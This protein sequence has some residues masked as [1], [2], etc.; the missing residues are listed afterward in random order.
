MQPAWV[1]T[2]RAGIGVVLAL[3]AVVALVL[4]WPWDGID[5]GMLLWL[6]LGIFL[7][8]AS[9]AERS[10]TRL[11]DEAITVTSGRTVSTLTREDILDL[12][13]DDPE[14]PWRVQAVVRDGRTVTLLG[15][16]PAEL[17]R[18]RAWHLRRRKA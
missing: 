3:C 14:R 4:A 18:L 7:I 11:G 6:G 15:V 8:W 16:P 13:H 1:P 2:L 17:A 5:L 10:G 12:R 9:R